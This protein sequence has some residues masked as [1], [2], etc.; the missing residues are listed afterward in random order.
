MVTRP[1]GKN[2]LV[3]LFTLSLVGYTVRYS[4]NKYYGQNIDSN[5]NLFEKRK[6]KQPQAAQALLAIIMIM[7]YRL[8]LI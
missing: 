2:N 6:S 7:S 1:N 3:N 5:Q 8:L 4:C